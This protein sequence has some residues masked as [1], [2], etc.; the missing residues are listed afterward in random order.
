MILKVK[1]LSP[2]AVLPKRAYPGDAGFD[3]VAQSVDY[4]GRDAYDRYSKVAVEFGIA[5]EIPAGHVGL[6]FARSSIYFTRLRLANAVGVIDSGYRGCL[7]AV[8]DIDH[9]L[10]EEQWYQVGDRCA[11]LVILP[12]PEVELVEVDELSPSERG[13]GS[14]GSSDRKGGQA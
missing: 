11:Q 6:I 7:S 5:V 1:K 10:S 12:L 13:T 2:D 14:Y 4:F 3:L 9:E 8:F